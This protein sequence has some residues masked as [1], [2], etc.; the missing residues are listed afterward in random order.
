MEKVKTRFDNIQIMKAVAYE[1]EGGWIGHLA[2]A[3]LSAGRED[4]E[5]LDTIMDKVI[6]KY[7]LSKLEKKE[8]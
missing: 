3:Y 8:K 1:F 6:I 2:M 7:N 4:R 5:L